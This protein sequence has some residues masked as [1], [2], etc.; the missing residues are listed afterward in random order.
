MVV[1]QGL[2]RI[3]DLYPG[4]RKNRTDWNRCSTM[5]SIHGLSSSTSGSV[6]KQASVNSAR[7]VHHETPNAD[8]VSE[9]ARP[10]IRS[11]SGT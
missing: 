10:V 3:N 8:A 9:T 5:P 7:T 2:C 6:R 4:S 11:T 1:I